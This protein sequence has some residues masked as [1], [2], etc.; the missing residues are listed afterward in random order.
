[1]LG[2]SILGRHLSLDVLHEA[3]EIF[4]RM[5][6]L[7]RDFTPFDGA[8]LEDCAA[9]MRA[10]APGTDVAV[11]GPSAVQVALERLRRESLIWNAG[12]GL[13]FVEDSRHA[14]WA[15]AGGVPPDL[16]AR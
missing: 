14:A 10:S 5:A 12:R 9:S 1:V 3:F 15:L 2:H 13:W 6:R 7:G 4:H 11:P 8:A 16:P